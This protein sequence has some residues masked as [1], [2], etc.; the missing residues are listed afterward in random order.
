MILHLAGAVFFIATLWAALQCDGIP[1]EV[2]GDDNEPTPP[3][4]RPRSQ[5]DIRGSVDAL[6][7]AVAARHRQDAG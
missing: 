3:T 5:A 1:C 2:P 6:T 4:K 7:A